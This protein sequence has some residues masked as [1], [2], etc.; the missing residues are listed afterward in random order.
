[1]DALA[2]LQHAVERRSEL[3]VLQ[4]QHAGVRLG[5]PSWR[6][7]LD[8]PQGG[9]CTI[10]VV[11]HNVAAMRPYDRLVL[12]IKRLQNVDGGL[13]CPNNILLPCPVEA[14]L[15]VCQ[16]RRVHHASAIGHVR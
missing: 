15:G 5:D 1:M 12:R 4:K 3:L 6:R 8:F 7:D 16:S 9:V 13:R 2:A 11:E 10:A 14:L